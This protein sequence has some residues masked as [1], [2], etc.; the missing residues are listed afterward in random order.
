MIYPWQM[1]AWQSVQ[2]AKM[3]NHLHHALLFSGEEG[4]GNEAFIQEVAKGLLCLKP[5]INGAACGECRSCQV[6]ASDAH[7]DFMSIRLLE[8]KQSIL[9]D[10]IRALNYFLGL[11]RSYSLR[12]VVVIYPADRMN[13]NAANSLLKSL[14]EPAP[15]TH[16]LLLTAHPAVLLPTIR[17][18]C[19]RARLPLPAH[20]DALE[21]L[22]QQV[23]Q[24]P[25]E[26]LLLNTAG[27]PLAALELDVTDT[28]V[29]REQWLTHLTECVQGQGS[30]TVI[31]SYWEKFDK[32]QLLDWQLGWLL[33]LLK[34]GVGGE[35]NSEVRYMQSVLGQQGILHIYDKLLELKKLST[36]PLNARLLLESMLVL[37]RQ[38]G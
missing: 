3:G 31:S 27:R 23:L 19:Q 10:Q 5:L 30:I 24:H 21:W 35:E 20:A 7:P 25:A 22:Q 8:D 37:W 6:F 34:Q 17:S 32:N 12:R 2:Q 26:Q 18:R 15:D 14:E 29:Q 36:H 9:I 1:Q 38:T 11:S 28:L 13:I 4:C 33:S 16:I